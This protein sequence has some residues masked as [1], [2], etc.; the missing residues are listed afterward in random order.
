LSVFDENEH[1]R[2]EWGEAE[3]ERAAAVEYDGKVPRA[4]AEGFA[5]LHPDRPSGDVPPRRWQQF[6]SD[7]G[8]F[9]DGPF[10]AIAAAI[11]WGPYDLFGADRDRS[12]AP[13][14]KLGCY[15]SWTATS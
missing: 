2:R 14:I 8:R 1:R 7:V 15:G 11:G 5:R 12:F 9:L 13:S 10:C 6:V 3:G 4:W